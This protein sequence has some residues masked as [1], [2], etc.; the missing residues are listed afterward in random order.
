MLE[1]KVDDT[2]A[3]ALFRRMGTRAASPAPFFKNVGTLVAISVRKNFDAGGR[4]SEE[5][6]WRG[7][8]R[9]WKPLSPFGKNAAKRVPLNLTARL[10]NSI[11]HR[12]DGSGAWVGTNT[13][14]AATQNFGAK[15]RVIQAKN[16]PCLVFPIGG[17]WIRVKKVVV[18]IPARPFLVVQA[19]DMAEI[20]TLG[21][22]FLAEI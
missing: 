1:I 15:N 6:S 3:L 8:T 14:Y 13:V 4:Y 9:S 2:A 22:T 18:N 17:R 11:T 12:A 20:Q 19:E 16:R 21:Q 10:R 5:G 7:G